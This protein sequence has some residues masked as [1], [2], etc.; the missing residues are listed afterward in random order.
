M[1]SSSDLKDADLRRKYQYGF[2]TSND[3]I[4]KNVI[5]YFETVWQNSVPIDLFS[6]LKN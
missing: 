5:Q 3:P 6:E 2:W 1:F 4:V